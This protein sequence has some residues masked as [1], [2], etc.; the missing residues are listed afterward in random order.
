VPESA[1]VCDLSIAFEPFNFVASSL[2]VGG[3]TFGIAEA[4]LGFIF[5]LLAVEGLVA[6]DR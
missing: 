2:N 4:M 3:G 5:A 1:D 6:D